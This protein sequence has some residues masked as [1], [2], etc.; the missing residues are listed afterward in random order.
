MGIIC[1]L[2]DLTGREKQNGGKIDGLIA[3][4]QKGFDVPLTFVIPA[5]NFT[6]MHDKTFSQELRKVL[7][8]FPSDSLL[9]IRSSALG[10]DGEDNS[11]AGI[12]NTVL[13]V[14]SND[15][16]AVQKAISE[17][18]SSLNTE[19]VNAYKGKNV[20]RKMGLII[21]QQISPVFAGVALRVA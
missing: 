19:V 11:F 17:V 9:A 3:L 8:V 1:K 10:E 18:C 4:S 16:Q 21:Q 2:E 15:E 12:F 5:N 20:P 13:N 6:H 14:A 7:A